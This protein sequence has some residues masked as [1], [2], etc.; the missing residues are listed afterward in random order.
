MSTSTKRRAAARQKTVAAAPEPVATDPSCEV[1]HVTGDEKTL[2]NL[3]AGHLPYWLCQSVPQCDLR[4]REARARELE[5]ETEAQ[6][7]AAAEEPAEVSQ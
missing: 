2:M 4:V 1:C 3:G 7:E 5:G 6:P